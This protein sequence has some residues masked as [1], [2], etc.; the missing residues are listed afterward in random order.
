[1][2]TP[3]VL[4]LTHFYFIFFHLL[5]FLCFSRKFP[6]FISPLYFFLS[7]FF[8]SFAF[9]F[10]PG[11]VFSLSVIENEDFLTNHGGP[12]VFVKLRVRAVRP[13]VHGSV[14][15]TPDP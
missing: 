9:S 14:S 12:G 3:V 11:S 2:L 5:L 8:L 1:M 6:I 10:Y 15:M 4:P 7:S 13:G